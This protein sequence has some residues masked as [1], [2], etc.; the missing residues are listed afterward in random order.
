MKS[1]RN[2]SK[3]AQKGKKKYVNNLEHHEKT[4]THLEL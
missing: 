2:E 4:Q 3:T 1:Q